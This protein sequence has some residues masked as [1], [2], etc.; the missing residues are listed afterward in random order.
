MP[1]K[2]NDNRFFAMLERRGIVRKVDDEDESLGAIIPSADKTPDT[3]MPPAN[4]FNAP[5]ITHAA[6]QPIP[7]MLNPIF[8]SGQSE[9]AAAAPAAPLSEPEL[10][11]PPE[12]HPMPDIQQYAEPQHAEPQYAEQQYA[13]QP[14]SVSEPTAT[15]YMEIQSMQYAETPADPIS[16]AFQPSEGAESEM[17][18]TLLDSNQPAAPAVA[19][20]IEKYLDI[21]SLYEALSLIA[22]KTNSI[23]LVEE[24]LNALPDT[25]PHESRREIVN[26]L[27]SVS[28][29][30]VDSLVRD[31]VLRVKTLK[32]YAERFTQYTNEFISGYEAELDDL[33]QQMMRIRR[34]IEDRRNLHKKQFFTIETEAQRLKEI[35]TFIS[36]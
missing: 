6:R 11:A 10:E 5:T 8:P 32:D 23:Y 7:G 26:R 19:N 21:V 22:E 14:Y 20:H 31:G 29:F 36:G 18:R 33:E 34:M 13:E 24:Y 15:D 2:Q 17:L 27:V 30:D 3:E 12:G 35:I 4:G 16:Q 25:I 1:D 28:G 9:P